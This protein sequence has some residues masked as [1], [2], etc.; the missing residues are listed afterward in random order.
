MFVLVLALEDEVT[1]ST[2]VTLDVEL[3]FKEIKHV[4]LVTIDARADF[5]EVKPR[6]LR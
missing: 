1:L 4:L 5:V 2:V 3:G 6:G